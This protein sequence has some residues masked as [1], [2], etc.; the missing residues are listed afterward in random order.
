MRTKSAGI[1]FSLPSTGTMTVRAGLGVFL[2]GEAYEDGFAHA[3]FPVF[4]ELLDRGLI[5]PGV[6][7]ELGGGFFLTVVHL[8]DAGPLGPGVG[9]SPLYG[10]LGHHFQLG[11]GGAAVADGGAHAVVARVAAAQ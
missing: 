6:R 3:A 1:S 8:E 2:G 7:A 9:F 11:H 10:G 5:D 4:Y